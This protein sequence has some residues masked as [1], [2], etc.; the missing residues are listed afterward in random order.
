MDFSAKLIRVDP[1][2]TVTL[3]VPQDIGATIYTYSVSGKGHFNL[4]EQNYFVS[5]YKVLYEFNKQSTDTMM[6]TVTNSDTEPLVFFTWYQAYSDGNHINEIEFGTEGTYVYNNADLPL[7]VYMK[8]WGQ[9]DITSNFYISTNLRG[10]NVEKC[11]KK[12]IFF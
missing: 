11:Q 10:Q 2:T 7:I 1:S 8:I 9:E 6:L 5:G 12:F 4:K 3:S